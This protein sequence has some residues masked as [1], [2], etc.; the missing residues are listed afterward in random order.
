MIVDMIYNYEKYWSQVMYLRLLNISFSKWVS[1]R[2]ISVHERWTVNWNS[3]LA[4]NGYVTDYNYRM[5]F[6]LGLLHMYDY[7]F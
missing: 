5:K 3:H 4:D 2:L 7:L 6:Y 1:W